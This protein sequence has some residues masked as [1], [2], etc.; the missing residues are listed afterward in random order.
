[1]RQRVR[2]ISIMRA[3]L[4]GAAL[5]LLAPIS[6]TAAPGGGPG[7][8]HAHVTPGLAKQAA[9]SPS[10][11]FAVIVQGD[12]GASSSTVT[13]AVRK[14]R[15]R[16]SAPIGAGVQAQFSSIS[17]VAATLSGDDIQALAD[18]PAVTSIT[19]NLP[20]AGTRGPGG[21]GAGAAAS[22][23]SNDQVWAAD[24]GVSPLWS[25]ITTA[26]L[27]TIA[28]VDS[29]VDPGPIS[30]NLLG[31]VSLYSGSGQNSRFDGYGHG[32]MVAGIASLSIAHHAGAAPGANIVSLDVLD[33]QGA[34]TEGDAIAAADWILKNKDAYNI[35]VANFSLSTGMGTSALYDPLDQAVE[36]LW[37][38]GVT[39]VT[40]AGNYG[41]GGATAGSGPLADNPISYWR[42]SE[43]SGTTAVD[44]QGVNPGTYSGGYTL[45]Q[46]GSAG[47]TAVTFDGKTG[48]IAL[49]NPSSLQLNSGTVEAWFKTSGNGRY[50]AIVA[51]GGQYYIGVNPNGQLEAWDPGTGRDRLTGVN[52]ADGVRHHVAMTFQN[53]VT[54]GTQIYLDGNLVLTTTLTFKRS[55]YVSIGSDGGS[56]EF[57]PGTIDDVAIYGTL[58]SPAQIAQHDAAPAA[59]S[60]SAGGP[61]G[62]VTAPANDPFVIT[63]GA[64]DTAGTPSPSDDFA[65]PWSSYGYTLDGFLK[66]ELGAPGR[67]INGPIPST[68]T[69]VQQ[70][71]N[72]GAGL[73]YMW[74]SG[75]S[76]AAPIVSGAVADLIALHPDWTPDQI[77]GA[78]MLSARAY[79]DPSAQF[80]LGVG[81]V[82]GA[83]AAAL[84]SPPNPNAAL[85][86]YVSTDPVTGLPVF[87]TAAWGSAASANAAW[88]SAAWGS[89]AWGSAAWGSAAWGSAAWGSAAWGSAAWG[90]AAWSSAAWG[91]AAWGSA[92]WGSAAW[93]SAAWG[94]AVN[95]NATPD[96]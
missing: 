81:I 27:P 68:S 61:S 54:N 72:R 6:A 62:V 10:A 49:G 45:G 78:L 58:L 85:D 35:K 53:G 34:G 26:N 12:P 87:D 48:S 19:P 67:M 5:V 30:K 42:L 74:M 23:Y 88:G 25:Q 52:V 38:S 82:N 44:A 43:S 95:A 40:A 33:D 51:T 56:A 32:T 80:S 55:G 9:D 20:I 63:V 7:G 84:A 50:G 79:A 37:F 93:G 22:T 57:F 39:V 16:H 66:P 75:T 28:I 14:V 83:G 11:S 70:F 96:G 1:M 94:S 59:G 3:A 65:A 92:A 2:R 24:A 89:A 8:P 46:P 90:S 15:A 13:A 76:F 4:I 36:K 86:A 31:Q 21:A 77:K 17:G 18:D 91:S 71:P 47:N 41:T 60:A 73:G 29:G 69:L 64:A